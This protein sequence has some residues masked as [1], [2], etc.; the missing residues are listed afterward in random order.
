MTDTIPNILIPK[1]EKVIARLKSLNI[2]HAMILPLSSGKINNERLHPDYGDEFINKASELPLDSKFVVYGFPALIHPETGVIF[3]YA[4]GMRNSYRLPETIANEFQV[5]REKELAQVRRKKIKQNSGDK[6]QLD[7][8]LPPLESNWVDGI[9]FTKNLLRKCY[10]YYGK[11]QSSRR[12]FHLNVAE[13]L[14]NAA[15]PPNSLDTLADRLFLPA[16]LILVLI[17]VLIGVYLFNNFDIGELVNN[18]LNNR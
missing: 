11:E 6:S 14:K 12:I 18:L 7:N 16:I 9:S 17:I 13:D 4:A 2:F 1:N 15:P 8:S 5:Y 3:G 10:D